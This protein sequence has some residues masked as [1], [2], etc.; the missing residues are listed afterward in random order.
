MMCALHVVWYAK[1]M[2]QDEMTSNSENF[3]TT[4]WKHLGS[5]ALLGLVIPGKGARMV[6]Y[7]ELV[8]G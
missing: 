8:F 7:V 3:V 2:S 5:K 6:L 4:Y 1:G